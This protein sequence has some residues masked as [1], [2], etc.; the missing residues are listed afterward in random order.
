MSRARIL[1]LLLAVLLIGATLVALVVGLNLRGEDGLAPVSLKTVDA[2]T[3]ARGAYLARA[4]NCIGC[5]TS[6]GGI[7]YAG[8]RG[9]ATPFGT[10]YAPNLTPDDE[11]GLGRW[12]EAE[13]WRAMHNG[14]SKDGH[15]LYPAFP[16]TSFTQVSRED[17]AAI[18]AFL[19]SLPPVAQPH[20]AHELR[21]PYNQ[22][23]AL[24]VWRALYFRPA[25]FEVDAL[26]SAQ[27]NRGAYLVRGLGHCAACHAGRNALGGSVDEPLLAGGL[28]PA[29][30]WQ[31]P[32]LALSE[33]GQQDFVALLK[34]GVSARGNV[35]GPMA[36]VVY[37]STSQ[38][39]E[40]DL[41][42]MAG[43][44]RTLPAAGRADAVERAEPAVMALGRKIYADRC[45]DCHGAHGQGRRVGDELLIPAL[46]GNASVNLAAPQNTV[47]AI[48]HGGFAPV[49][50][51]NPRPA[52][53]PPFAQTLSE[54]EVAAVASFVRQSWGNAAPPVSAL[55]VLHSR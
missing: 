18:Y 5:H 16:Y 21:F 30:N 25:A 24:A 33:S 45:L 28:I 7:D 52:G 26:Q 38:L 55:D 31:A 53:M 4:G 51:G 9:I 34:N 35:M 17:S 6:R 42:A 37:R 22:Q 14:R 54:A 50:A 8:G 23:A 20:R 29:L 19:R 36:E 41:Q 1:K 10:V 3:L 11:T 15:L 12:S 44:L 13:F 43:Y 2:G 27:W 47:L 49:T 40:Q 48:L 46:A 39:G 32:S